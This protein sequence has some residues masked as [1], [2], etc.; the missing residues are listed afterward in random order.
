MNKFKIYDILNG[1]GINLSSGRSSS[2]NKSKLKNKNFRRIK[3]HK[4]SVYLRSKIQT[5]M[6]GMTYFKSQIRKSINQTS[7]LDFSGIIH[8]VFLHQDHQHYNR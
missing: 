5:P 7:D 1:I 3:Y 6:Y 8:K 4:L 2:E